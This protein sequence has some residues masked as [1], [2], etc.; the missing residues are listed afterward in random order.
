[1]VEIEEFHSLYE[2]CVFRAWKQ[3]G[4]QVSLLHICGNATRVI[5]L[6]AETG[7]DLIEIDNKVDLAMA[8]RAIGDRAA[9]MGNVHTVTELLDGTPASV[10]AAAQRCI[11]QAGSGG[12]F[13]LG[14][15]CIVPRRAP[16]ENVI[17]MVR[18][19]HSQPY[20]IPTSGA[21]D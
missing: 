2:R 7:A 20:P 16:L 10:R 18:V 11:D 1:M 13:V 19:A 8:K 17:E 3:H 21:S 6:Y 5:D 4:V 12:G 14:S 9:L 15:G